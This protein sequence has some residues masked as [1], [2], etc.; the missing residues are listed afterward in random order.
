[1]WE[2]VLHIRM[3]ERRRLKVEFFACRHL[4]ENRAEKI[5]KTTKVQQEGVKD[6]RR[7]CNFFTPL[8]LFCFCLGASKKTPDWIEN[9]LCGREAIY[10]SSN[11]VLQRPLLGKVDKS[12]SYCININTSLSHLS[13]EIWQT[14]L[15]SL[16]YN[17]SYPG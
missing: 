8:Y 15:N 11:T 9:V 2:L 10:C 1:M 16:T 7:S 6:N 12:L 4:S 13:R 3:E 17:F 14:H 5:R